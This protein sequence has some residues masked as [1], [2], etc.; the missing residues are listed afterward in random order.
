MG[1]RS[2]FG[3]LVSKLKGGG[4]PVKITVDPTQLK[5][6]DELFAKF[7][8]KADKVIMRAIN[9]TAKKANTITLKAITSHI[10]IKRKDIAAKDGKAPHS[11]GGVRLIQATQRT[12]KARISVTGKRIPLVWFRA[13]QLKGKRAKLTNVA[14]RKTTRRRMAG[15][16]VRYKI[17]KSGATKTIPSAFIAA[18]KKGQG[19]L[20][21]SQRAIAR[22]RRQQYDTS[23]H[24]GVFVRRGRARLP[25]DQLF[26]PSI[27]HVATESQTLK[28]A[29]E[30]DV[31]KALSDRL[32]HQIGRLLAK[33]GGT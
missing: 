16:G 14:T 8:D 12:L 24:I 13:R 30:I 23:G 7:P 9:H 5:Q 10:N 17:L 1:K 21:V 4:P 19:K 22:A 25:I 32:D 27:P 29:L 31:T 26:G 3:G 2:F 20:G 6:I 15:G 28:R 18:G 33:R 11:F